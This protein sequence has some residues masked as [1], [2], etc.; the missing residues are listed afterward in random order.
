MTLVS[1]L[2]EYI[3]ACFTGLWVQSHEHDDALAEIAQMCRD[4]D[5]RLV[6]WDVNQG[7]QLNRQNDGASVDTGTNDP[8][9]AIRSLDALGSTGGAF[10]CH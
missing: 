5:W 2:Q 6:V 8:L 7:L 10:P 4:Q 1:R 3:A 9:A